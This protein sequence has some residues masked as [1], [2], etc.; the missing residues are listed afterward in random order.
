MCPQEA[1]EL[2]EAVTK[3][4]S[5]KG[6]LKPTELI[7]AATS[8]GKKD[9]AFKR[10]TRK[11]TSLEG[12]WK[13]PLC[14][15]FAQSLKT[16]NPAVYAM[17]TS[18]AELFQAGANSSRTGHYKGYYIKVTSDTLHLSLK[19]TEVSLASPA[20]G[21]AYNR[22]VE[23]MHSSFRLLHFCNELIFLVGHTCEM[24]LIVNLLRTL[25][26]Q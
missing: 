13:R 26:V 14:P 10:S 12:S 22:L 9:F 3:L 16:R 25:Q 8:H 11:Y 21:T 6:L 24:Q 20:K 15:G 17:L 1:E 5:G 4:N 18:R 19:R 23:Q 7:A 2:A